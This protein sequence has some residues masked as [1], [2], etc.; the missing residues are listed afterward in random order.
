[1]TRL[2]R[3]HD[4]VLIK[5]SPEN[6]FPTVQLCTLVDE[7]G[8]KIR[9]SSTVTTTGKLDFVFKGTDS[10]TKCNCDGPFADGLSAG[11]RCHRDECLQK[12]R[13]E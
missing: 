9:L 10:T 12:R 1:M 5:S 11:G 13:Y 8:K 6:Q 7:N 4:K 2:Q 3:G